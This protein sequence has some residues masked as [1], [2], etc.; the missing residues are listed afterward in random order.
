MK[1][2][3][4]LVLVA[5]MAAFIACG[6]SKKDKEKAKAKQDSLRLDSIAKVRVAYSLAAVEKENK[7]LDSI[8]QDTTKKTV[9]HKGTKNKKHTSKT[10]HKVNSKP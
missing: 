9:K 7:R 6:P 4:A 1:K 3:I 8:K 2:L 5:G 10:K